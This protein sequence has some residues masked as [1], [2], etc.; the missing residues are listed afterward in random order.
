MPPE[1]DARRYLHIDSHGT[2][3][4]GISSDYSHRGGFAMPPPNKVDWYVVAAIVLPILFVIV[5]VALIS[6]G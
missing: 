4:L 3:L 1:A 6:A 2:P 5:L